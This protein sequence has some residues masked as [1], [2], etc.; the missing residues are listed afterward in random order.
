M[1]DIAAHSNA[2]AA[3]RRGLSAL[4][5]AIGEFFTT[6]AASDRR[7]RQVDYLQSLTDAELAERGI[8]REEIVHHVFRDTYYV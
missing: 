7:L 6:V 8:R 3:P 4:F 1:A 5:A 2:S